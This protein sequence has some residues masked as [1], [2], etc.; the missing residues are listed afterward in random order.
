MTAASDASISS[1]MTESNVV[2]TSLSLKDKKKKALK[3]NTNKVEPKEI[4]ANKEVSKES[5]IEEDILPDFISIKED[6]K[7]GE[8]IQLGFAI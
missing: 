6:A 1:E 2:V 3:P 8:N 4:A 5:E 7:E